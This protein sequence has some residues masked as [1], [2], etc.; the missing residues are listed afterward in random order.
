MRIAVPTMD[1]KTISEHF[2]RCRAFMIF[3]AEGRTIQGCK[4]RP[5]AKGGSHDHQAFAELLSDCQAV[6]VKGMGPGSLK[7]LTGA[8][9]EVYRA[10][11][12]ATPEEAIFRFLSGYLKPMEEEGGEEQ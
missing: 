8:G 11:P 12:S 3:E 2:G 6:I 5:N 4:A 9:L 1:G 10:N 7:A